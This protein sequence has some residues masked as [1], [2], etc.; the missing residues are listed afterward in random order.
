MSF[1]LGV[2]CVG[3]GGTH[4]DTLADMGRDLS[5]PVDMALDDGGLDDGGLDDGGLDDGGLDDGGLDDGG[6][7]D[8]GLDD[9]GQVTDMGHDLSQPMDVGL[10]D[11][12]VDQGADQGTELAAP[13]VRIVH[14][15]SDLLTSGDIPI[16]GIRI[17]SEIQGLGVVA[18]PP[19]TDLSD[20]FDLR[21]GLPFR[22][23]T[24][25]LDTLPP[26]TMRVYDE[27][28][29]DDDSVGAQPPAI[30][31]PTTGLDADCTDDSVPCVFQLD[32][33]PA[34][35]AQGSSY[36]LF[37]GGFV[38]NTSTC[39]N[40]TASCPTGDITATLAEDE[41][42]S[43]VVVGGAR[44]RFFHGIHNLMPVDVCYDL[45]GLAMNNAVPVAIHTSV[46]AGTLSEYVTVPVVTTGLVF[47]TVKNPL[48][49][50]TLSSDCA[51]STTPAASGLPS[52]V[53]PVFSSVAHA[54][55]QDPTPNMAAGTVVTIFATG[56]TRYA[57][58]PAQ[59]PQED[60]LGWANYAGR[61]PFVVTYFE[62]APTQPAPR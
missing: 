49:P 3:C 14:A 15:V 60:P 43:D 55:S 61:T 25:Y 39:L 11:G 4:D 2:A 31:C 29:V 1:L 21:F 35:L 47:L 13:Q 52:N 33:D 12:G 9:G 40:G 30:H 19:N 41:G 34:A 22:A 54:A 36:S 20:E 32:Y 24:P 10:D 8:G 26:S 42:A 28:L 62:V 53:I 51:L 45:D 27:A 5:A 57:T 56:D 37:V 50:S 38:D 59:P 48:D 16:R 6:L 44:V 18:Q 58:A 7:D 17:C 23:V 46:A